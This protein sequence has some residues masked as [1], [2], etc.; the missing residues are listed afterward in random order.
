MPQITHMPLDAAIEAR[1]INQKV[2]TNKVHVDAIRS[3]CVT[4]LDEREYEQKEQL[5][6]NEERMS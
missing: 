6:M 3:D 5:W 2:Y 4:L 1:R